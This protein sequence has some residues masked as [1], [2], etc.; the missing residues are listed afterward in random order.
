MTFIYCAEYN[1]RC[2]KLLK[3]PI[4][5]FFFRLSKEKNTHPS[6][7]GVKKRINCRFLLHRRL[8]SAQSLW[9]YTEKHLDGALQKYISE[10]D[11]Y[12]KSSVYIDTCIDNDV[13][14]EFL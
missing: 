7:T 9:Q 11:N 2:N 6:E 8:Y 4:K 13:L 5:H 3:S 10:D 1:L 14:R 12:E